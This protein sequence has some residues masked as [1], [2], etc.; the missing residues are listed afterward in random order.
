MKTDQFSA[1]SQAEIEDKV[2]EGEFNQ[3]VQDVVNYVKAQYAS[4]K[5]T[6]GQNVSDDD[7]EN[8]MPNA[9]SSEFHQGEVEE[10]KGMEEFKGY[11]K[12]FK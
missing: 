10:K 11:K 7:K 6:K 1:N 3:K 2:T 5:M 12:P 8:M 9:S 4:Q